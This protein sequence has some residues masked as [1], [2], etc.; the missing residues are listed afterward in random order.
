MKDPVGL[1]SDSVSKVEAESVSGRKEDCSYGD[2]STKAGIDGKREGTSSLNMVSDKNNHWVGSDD[3]VTR[4]S[5][6]DDSLSLEGDPILD[7]SCSLSVASETSSI[8]GEE[9]LGFDTT[10]IGPSASVDTEKGTSDIVLAAK[11]IDLGESSVENS[12]TLSA[13]GSIEDIGD[14]S[15]TTQPVVLQLPLE[16]TVSRTVARSV[17]ELDYIPLWGYTSVCGRR[18]EM[19]DAV[20][21][22]PHFLKIPI[23]MLIGDRIIDGMSKHY[24]LQTAHFFGVYDGHGGSQVPFYI[25][26]F[27]RFVTVAV[28]YYFFLTQDAFNILSRLLTIVG[29]AYMLLYLRKLSS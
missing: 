14:G 5:E 7:S 10:D 23:E 19:E 18:P 4:E 12:P 21:T 3:A 15:R 27:T 1:L 13:T 16:R 25:F 9:F 17:F 26:S 2:L 20:A 28:Y 8:C 6:E 24:M 11:V 29:I 22:V